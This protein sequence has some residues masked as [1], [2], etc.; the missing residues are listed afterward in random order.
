MNEYE[1]QLLDGWEEVFK[2]GQ[3]TLWIM[4]ALRR[5]YEVGLVE[6]TQEPGRNGPDRKVYALSD[7]GR[8][9]LDQFLERNIR[10]VFYQPE[11]KRLIEGK[12]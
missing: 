2:K 1:Q 9:V 12:S 6:F 7:I 5:Y 10:S 8:T 11:L 3:L 4:L